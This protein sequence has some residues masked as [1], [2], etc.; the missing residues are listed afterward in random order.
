M[1]YA[2]AGSQSYPP[3][4][5][6]VLSFRWTDPL[7]EGRCWS[8]RLVRDAVGFF[9]IDLSEFRADGRRRPALEGGRPRRRGLRRGLRPVER[10]RLGREALTHG[11]SER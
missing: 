3:T 6:A 2:A 11:G 5:K 9:A 7:L 10:H 4:S 8:E 1:P